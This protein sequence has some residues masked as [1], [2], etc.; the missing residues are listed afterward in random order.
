MYNEDP[1][2]GGG[3]PKATELGGIVCV[4]CG[5]PFVEGERLESS[6]THVKVFHWL[7]HMVGSKLFG[8]S[9]LN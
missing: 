7:F 4:S 8:Q 2:Y 6:L 9:S 1:E 5:F 3:Y